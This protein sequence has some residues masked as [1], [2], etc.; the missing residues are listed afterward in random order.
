MEKQYCFKCI[1]RLVLLISFLANISDVIG[2]TDKGQNFPIPDSINKVF[3]A[4]CMPCHGINGGRL[5]TSRLNF[6]RWA[7]YGPAKE[8]EK[9]SLICSV[10]T[11]GSMPP[12]SARESRPELIPT[13]NQKDM[14][15]K[16][17]ESIKIL[18]REKK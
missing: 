1:L 4:S 16:W 2:Q 7:G 10:L 8:A 14:I 15:C 6:S 11:K 13:E 17:A 12:R 5:P 9:A 3:Q 18:K